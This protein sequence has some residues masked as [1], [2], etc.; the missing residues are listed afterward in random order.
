MPFGVVHDTM[1]AA[2]GAPQPQ[3]AAAGHIPSALQYPE[4]VFAQ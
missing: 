1:G 3:Q 2:E 4:S